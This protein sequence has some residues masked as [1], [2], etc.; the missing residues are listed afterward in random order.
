MLGHSAR[1]SIILD[2]FLPLPSGPVTHIQIYSSVI[3]N[4]NKMEIYRRRVSNWFTRQPFNLRAIV[5]ITIHNYHALF[6]LSWQIKRRMGCMLCVFGTISSFLEGSRKV[7]Y[8]WYMC[9]LAE[10]DRYQSK[11]FYNFLWHVW[12]T[13]CYGNKTRWALYFCYGPNHPDHLWEVLK[14]R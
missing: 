13:F 5:F 1:T 2:S 14:E 11:K 10:G 9:L 3:R 6:V 8:L 4:T 12:I 7:I